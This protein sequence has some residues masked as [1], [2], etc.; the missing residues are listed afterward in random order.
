MNAV[1]HVGW[2]NLL[3]NGKWAYFDGVLDPREVHDNG[4]TWEK[5]YVE[6]PETP[7]THGP[8]SVCGQETHQ[9]HRQFGQ[10]IWN[11]HGPGCIP[12]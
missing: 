3:G 12:F 6:A 10:R 4:K 1:I 5:V 8:C 7:I 9:V 2:R 11:C